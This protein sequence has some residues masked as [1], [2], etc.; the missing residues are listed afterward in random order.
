MEEDSPKNEANRFASQFPSLELSYQHIRNVL[1]Q[2]AQIADVLGMKAASLWA[3]ATAVVGIV[4]PLAFFKRPDYLS[5]WSLA[6]LIIIGFFYLS[7]TCLSWFIIF[8]KRYYGI[9]NI[10]KIKTEFASLQK[11]RFMVDMISHIEESYKQNRQKLNL[12]GWGVRGLSI[13]VFALIILLAVWS[14]V[15]VTWSPPVS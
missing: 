5:G 14:Y 7:C 3:V 10:E 1:E 15:F 6:L 11:E 2:Q 8:P 13:A 9:A 12:Q 4:I